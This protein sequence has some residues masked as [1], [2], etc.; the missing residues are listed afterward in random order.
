L[1][2]NSFG[3]DDIIPVGG[4]LFTQKLLLHFPGLVIASGMV[5]NYYSHFIF[6]NIFSIMFVNIG[7][8]VIQTADET[9]ISERGSALKVRVTTDKPTQGTAFGIG[10]LYAVK[11]GFVPVK[12]YLF[13]AMTEQADAESLKKLAGFFFASLLDTE[14][15]VLEIPNDSALFP[16]EAMRIFGHSKHER[17]V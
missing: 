10:T 17:A 12:V 3:D 5:Q 15:F 13:Q 2:N 11:G 7:Y 16:Q 4:V 8:E 6:T 14:L 9:V 1:C